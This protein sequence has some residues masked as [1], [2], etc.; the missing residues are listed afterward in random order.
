VKNV[1]KTDCGLATDA[2]ATS[3]TVSARNEYLLM[4]N[5]GTESGTLKP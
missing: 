5:S 3:A 4:V 1:E 2:V